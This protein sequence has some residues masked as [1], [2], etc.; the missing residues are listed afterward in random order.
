MLD[1]SRFLSWL[2]I[3]LLRPS[4]PL[5]ASASPTIYKGVAAAAWMASPAWLFR[6]PL[7]RV[8]SFGAILMA[9]RERCLQVR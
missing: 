2:S 8:P 3:P 9:A 6:N 1:P 7:S 5:G 4:L